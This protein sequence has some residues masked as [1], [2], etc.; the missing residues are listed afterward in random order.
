MDQEVLAPAEMGVS[1]NTG[2]VVEVLILIGIGVGALALVEVPKEKSGYNRPCSISG[3]ES[4]ASVP[5]SNG[6]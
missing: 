1:S 6:L 3:G 5:V 2:I 4:F